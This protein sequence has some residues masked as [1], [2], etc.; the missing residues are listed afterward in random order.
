MIDSPENHEGAPGGLTTE[1]RPQFNQDVLQAAR[2]L[3]G[4]PEFVLNPNSR[5]Q[6]ENMARYTGIALEPAE[7]A[8]YCALRERVTILSDQEVLA[9]VLYETGDMHRVKQFTGFYS[10]NIFNTRQAGR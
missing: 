4:N 10:P 1:G 6:A 7:V 8:L 2:E 5:G 9:A 3:T